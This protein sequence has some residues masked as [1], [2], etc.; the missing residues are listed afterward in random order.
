M[1]DPASA[2]FYNQPNPDQQR[3]D[4]E[5]DPTLPLLTEQDLLA[6][7]DPE[8]LELSR[9]MLDSVR[10]GNPST[11]IETYAL[12]HLLAKG[13][14]AML[15]DASLRDIHGSPVAKARISL[16]I[17]ETAN[18][19]ASTDLL[20]R[21]VADAEAFGGVGNLLERQLRDQAK[22]EQA[23][24]SASITGDTREDRIKAMADSTAIRRK[25]D[26]QL[27]NLEHRRIAAGAKGAAEYR[28]DSRG[29][30]IYG[31]MLDK[32]IN[33]RTEQVLQY[34]DVEDV[35]GKTKDSHET[36]AD[37]F[38]QEAT[39][40]SD[41]IKDRLADFRSG[42]MSKEDLRTYAGVAAGWIETLK[43]V[44][45]EPKVPQSPEVDVEETARQPEA[46]AKE[47]EA[48]AKETG[49][50]EGELNQLLIDKLDDLYDKLDPEK[51]EPFR[52]NATVQEAMTV[53]LANVLKR[54][55]KKES[56]P[57]QN[58][59]IANAAIET[60]LI[61]LE[62]RNLRKRLSRRAAV[63]A[64]VLGHSVRAMKHANDPTA[65]QTSDAYL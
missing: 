57:E 23:T 43:G 4:Q 8:A 11:P 32:R 47:A 65:T 56:D 48:G 7:T 49:Q 62:Y 53:V 3:V 33:L 34:G 38:E 60:A 52:L 22:A 15:G 27:S 59:V 21:L 12:A 2:E 61:A 37:S 40:A 42:K 24:H 16:F 55:R 20:E 30:V 9:V 50:P 58:L 63:G 1:Y 36:P 25:Y 54:I 31:I 51:E 26:Q 29:N 17:D 41:S 45:E 64:I 39:A 44:F 28:S 35:L 18:R 10:P 19:V 5:F 13:S 6:Y 46:E 14:V